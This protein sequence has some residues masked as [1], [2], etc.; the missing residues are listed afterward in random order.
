MRVRRLQPAHWIVPSPGDRIWEV[1]TSTSVTYENVQTEFSLSLCL[2][3]RT[4]S[5][6]RLE[7]KAQ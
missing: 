4:P 2:A 1:K 3:A 5:C 7:R 6:V